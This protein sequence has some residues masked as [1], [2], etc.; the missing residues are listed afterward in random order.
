MILIIQKFTNQKYSDMKLFLI[1][2]HYI[3]IIISY[4]SACIT[5]TTVHNPLLKKPLVLQTHIFY[6]NGYLAL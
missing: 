4:N 2:C 5:A 6:I 3:Q 1:S